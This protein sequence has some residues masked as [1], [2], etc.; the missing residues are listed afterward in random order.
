LKTAYNNYHKIRSQGLE[1]AS[2][3][4]FVWSVTLLKTIVYQYIHYGE[5][6][7]DFF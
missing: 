2:F 7:G 6:I 1:Q 4:F 3:F 5:N